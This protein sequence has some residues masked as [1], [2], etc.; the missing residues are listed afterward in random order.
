M[1]REKRSLKFKFE[2]WPL[3]IGGIMKIKRANRLMSINDENM[4]DTYIEAEPS[5]F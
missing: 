4:G 1:M 3:I 5:F 2:S